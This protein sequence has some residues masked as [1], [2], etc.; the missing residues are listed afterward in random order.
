VCVC[1]Y[2]CVSLFAYA[3]ALQSVEY[4][5][6]YIYTLY[7][8]EYIYLFEERMRSIYISR[9]IYI[10]VH[11]TVIVHSHISVEYTDMRVYSHKMIGLFCKT[12]LSKRRHSAKETYHF[13][14]PTNRSRAYAQVRK[15]WSI[16]LWEY[17]YLCA[18]AQVSSVTD[19]FLSKVSYLIHR[20]L[21]A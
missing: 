7:I 9:Y 14:E 3:C 12:A 5:C 21:V 4:I 15:V 11:S 10:R 8:Y 16:Y 2:V 17:I 1:V 18:Y 13:K 20:S 19:K 6:L